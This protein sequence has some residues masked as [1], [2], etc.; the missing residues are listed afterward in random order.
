MLPEGKFAVM[1]AAI[2][3]AFTFSLVGLFSTYMFMKKGSEFIGD[4]NIFTASGTGKQ[5]KGLNKAVSQ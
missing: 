2:A 1:L 5:F 3:I 4:F